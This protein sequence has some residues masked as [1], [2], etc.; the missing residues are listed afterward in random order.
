MNAIVVLYA[1]ASTGQT[2][3]CA[4]HPTKMDLNAFFMHR[5]KFI[6]NSLCYMSMVSSIFSFHNVSYVQCVFQQ[7]KVDREKRQS[8]KMRVRLDVTVKKLFF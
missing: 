1:Y 6:N 4:T 3:M 8:V 2:H 7:M 5:T